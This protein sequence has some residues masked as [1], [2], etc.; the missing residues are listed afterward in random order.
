MRKIFAIALVLAS[1]AVGTADA[2][3]PRKESSAA[4]RATEDVATGSVVDRGAEAVRVRLA[5]IELRLRT[6]WRMRGLPVPPVPV[7]P[8]NETT[9]ITDNPDPIGERSGSDETIGLSGSNKGQ[10]RRNSDSETI[11]GAPP[12]GGGTG[13]GDAGSGDGGSDGGSGGDGSGGSGD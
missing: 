8:A 6:L 12:Q 11:G 9:Q 5:G 3:S 1:S 7:P 10:H 13:S 4:P 2:A